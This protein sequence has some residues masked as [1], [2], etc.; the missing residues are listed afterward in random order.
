MSIEV[1]TELPTF[2]VA[3][4]AQL[5]DEFGAYRDLRAASRVAKAGLGQWAVTRHA[6]VSALLRDR[7]L[8]HHMPREYLQFAFGDGPNR[9]LRERILLNRD[10]EDH[11]RLRILMGKAFSA[12]LVR[13]LREHIGDLVDGLLEPLLDRAEFDVVDDLALPLPVAVICELLGIGHVDRAEVASHTRDL[14]APD[15]PAADRAV[16][17]IRA[18]VADV[19]DARTADPDGDLLQRMLAAEHGDQALTH[20]EIVDNAA[21]LFVAGFETT[22]HLIASGVHALLDFPDQLDLLLGDPALA[23]TAVEELLRFDGPVLS[24]PVVATEPI[25]IGTVRIKAARVLHLL[26]R[27]ANRDDEVFAFPEALDIRR[28]PNPHVAFGGGVHHCLGSMLARVEGEVVFR[29]LASRVGAIDRT[30]PTERVL[31][32]YRHVPVTAKP[33]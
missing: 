7:R 33:R 31:G 12:P 10:G 15:R 24:V 11:T 1:G 29:R 13:Q 14:F 25:D 28:A 27:C 21:L 17:W 4:A 18:Y 20:E 26:L 5:E 2:Y 3:T 30:A 9:E 32:Q 23:Q 22:K 6:D 8:V 19:L 16:E